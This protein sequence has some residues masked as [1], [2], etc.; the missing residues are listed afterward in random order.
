ML[1]E[2]GNEVMENGYPKVVKY[3]QWRLP[4]KAEIEVIIKFQH[5]S[6]AMDEVMVGTSYWSASGLVTNPTPTSS[7]GQ[8]I[9]CVHDAYGDEN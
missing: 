3:D 9:R 2:N 7:S 1:D 8:F 4:T 5:T 6:D